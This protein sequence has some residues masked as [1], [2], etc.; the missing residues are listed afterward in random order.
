[1]MFAQFLSIYVPL[2]KFISSLN[3]AGFL[4]NHEKAWRL[5][6]M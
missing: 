5:K 4:K 3:E 6:D 1:M 2:S